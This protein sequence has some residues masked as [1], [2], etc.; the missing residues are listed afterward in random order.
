M[1]SANSST[2]VKKVWDDWT[3]QSTP[4]LPYRYNTIC[5]SS[6]GARVYMSTFST[7]YTSTD[8]GVTWTALTGGPIQAWE[9]CCS[10]DGSFVAGVNS[11]GTFYYS[12]NYGSTWNTVS[13]DGGNAYLVSCS[14]S[15]DGTKVILAEYYN[16]ST[17]AAGQMWFSTNSGASFSATYPQTSSWVN[18]KL[19]PD[20]TKAFAVSANSN[21]Y[22]YVGTISGS[23]ISWSQKTS[24]LPSGAGYA[25]ACSNNGAKVVACIGGNPD[26]YKSSDYGATWT[27]AGGLYGS[28]SNKSLALSSDG[29]TFLGG[30]GGSGGL[31]YSTDFLSTLKQKTLGNGNWYAGVAMKSDGKILYAAS[32]NTGGGFYSSP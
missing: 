7:V 26:L 24:G 29:N 23:S 18:V 21:M 2:A 25:L 17:Y 19:T 1:F 30:G 3:A 28:P 13:I 8:Y 10:S 9:M 5:C 16:S 14:C 27:Y 12:T 6:T 11:T 15:S 4:A 31:T 20:G 32:G 22:V